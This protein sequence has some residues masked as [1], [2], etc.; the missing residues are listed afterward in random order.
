MGP[1]SSRLCM[2]S[3]VLKTR[4]QSLVECSRPCTAT[5]GVATKQVND[6]RGRVEALEA[7]LVASRR[8][9][10]THKG[11]G[12]Q[13]EFAPGFFR[14]GGP[15]GSSI[16]GPAPEV[17][18]STLVPADAQALLY[19]HRNL[20]WSSC[21]ASLSALLIAAVP[22]LPAVLLPGAPSPSTP[23]VALA[24]AIMVLSTFN[25][26]RFAALL[27]ASRASPAPARRHVNGSLEHARPEQG[28]GSMEP[29][30]SPEADQQPPGAS[31]TAQSH[32]NGALWLLVLSYLLLGAL[33]AN[34]SFFLLSMVD[35]WQPH[36]AHSFPFARYRT[37]PKLS[38]SPVRS[39]AGQKEGALT[40]CCSAPFSVEYFCTRLCT[41][42]G[43]AMAMCDAHIAIQLLAVDIPCGQ[44]HPRMHCSRSV[45]AKLRCCT[46]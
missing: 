10:S 18:A 2:I 21:K 7:Q 9:E 20:L 35:S 26:A 29:A 17:P 27:R 46:E 37:A 42:I 44:S 3:P 11:Q 8:A 23:S 16:A 6:L 13:S 19:Q 33:L 32:A 14:K 41:V 12:L 31:Q 28:Q 34:T 5:H 22:V 25:A 30:G 1:F 15:S 40:S 24:I 45:Q 39:L 36:D 38:P 43:T 4:Q